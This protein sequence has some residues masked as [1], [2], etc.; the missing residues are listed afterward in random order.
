MPEQELHHFA[1]RAAQCVVVP[2]LDALV[3]RG[4]T[5]R[6]RTRGVV[7]GLVAAAVAIGGVLVGTR[8]DTRAQD[9]PIR[10]PD[11]APVETYLAGDGTQ[12]LEPGTYRIESETWFTALVTVPEGWSSWLGPVRGRT[13]ESMVAMLVLEVSAVASEACQLHVADMTQ[14]R[15]DPAAL[16]EA[17]QALPRHRVILAPRP[18]DRFGFPATHLAVEASARARCPYR[19][20][21]IF[22]SG[23]WGIESAGP[24]SRMDLWVV[25][26]AGRT[27]VVVAT[28]AEAATDRARE[29]LA[30]MV[31]SIRLE[32]RV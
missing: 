8:L 28:T 14:V 9:H 24:H 29:Q 22:G 32:P 12:P 2:D 17:L 30:A 4:V 18:D 23:D 27:A 5:R 31:G 1:R 19:D 10:P 11:R 7:A 25:D 20:F 3:R 13:D 16:V 21:L 26:V 6:R 15:S